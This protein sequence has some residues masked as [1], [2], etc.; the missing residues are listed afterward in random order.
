MGLGCAGL[1]GVGL[2]VAGAV[3]VEQVGRGAE[4]FGVAGR[5]APAVVDHHQ[6]VVGHHHPIP[7]HRHHGAGGRGHAV[8][9]DGLLPLV[10]GED[11][12]DRQALAGVAAIGK[13][14]DRHV[15]AAGLL[16]GPGHIG[17]QHVNAHV[18]V[19]LQDRGRRCCFHRHT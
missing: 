7:S 11:V 2:A 6:G 1:A 19:E 12:V 9:H 18:P 16:Q 17:S 15:P 10:A 8:D 5:Q 14:V 4:G 3:G 13:Q